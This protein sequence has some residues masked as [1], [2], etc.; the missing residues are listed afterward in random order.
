MRERRAW[1][2][3]QETTEHEEQQ[4]KSGES[5][6]R[7]KTTSPYGRPSPCSAAARP[8]RA[9]KQGA[10]HL[11]SG[12]V[13]RAL[14]L[15]LSRLPGSIPQKVV[16]KFLPEQEKATQRRERQ[17]QEQLSK[18]WR[19]CASKGLENHSKMAQKMLPGGSK[20][21]QNGSRR[22]PGAPPRAQPK[23]KPFLDPNLTP[24][25]RFQIALGAARGRKTIL[26]PPPWRP[27]SGKRGHCQA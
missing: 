22:P 12:S 7:I 3:E 1:Q 11:R 6:Q 2:A 14:P 19:E 23:R 21:F 13:S 24:R 18:M 17:E 9:F 5:S 25:V 20:S 27:K 4:G 10:L 26:G 8:R 15:V 16:R